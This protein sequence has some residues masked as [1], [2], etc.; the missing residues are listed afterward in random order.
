MIKRESWTEYVQRITQGVPRKEV[1]KAAGINV[2]GLSRWINAVGGRPRAEKVVAFARGLRQSPVEAL[3]AADYLDPHEVAGVIEVVRSRG[4]IIELGERLTQGP[5]RHEVD[6]ITGLLA[7]P[8]DARE[9][10][11]DGQG[12]A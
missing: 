7:R 3:I 12:F 8:D 2:S 1:A 5:T 6:D 4:V 10:F 9:G 11:E